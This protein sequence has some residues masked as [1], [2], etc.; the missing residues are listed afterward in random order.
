MDEKIIE[1]AKEIKRS[2]R[3]MMDGVTSQSMRD[4]GADY[5]VNWGASLPMLRAKAKEMGYDHDL[6]VEL[7]KDNVRECKILA[8]MTMP[9]EEMSRQLAELWMDQTTTVEM[10]E[11]TAMYLYCHLP[12][13]PEMAYKWMAADNEMRQICGYHIL[14]RLF[15]NGQEP[16]ERGINEYIDQ[17]QTAIMGGSM[18]VKKAA[19]ASIQRFASLGLVYERMAASAM[20]RCG[21]D[22]F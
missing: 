5:H 18:A 13:A 8:A 2:F 1:R 17:A 22:M 21:I 15:M 10:A 16:N 3:L 4:K 6:A 14:A 20:K 9:P 11:I 19:L 7:W 12:Y